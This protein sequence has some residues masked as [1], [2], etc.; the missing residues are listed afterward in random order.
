LIDLPL[1][2]IA[3]YSKRYSWL[4]SRWVRHEAEAEA[5]DPEWIAIREALAFGK[6]CVTDD[7]RHAL[8]SADLARRVAMTADEIECIEAG[9][10][11]PTIALQRWTLTCSSP[12]GLTSA[13][14]GS[15]PTQP[16]RIKQPSP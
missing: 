13:P 4:H 9:G 11:E 3:N 10:T 16:D 6:T 12:H 2:H 7:R 1:T 5:E 14:C 15:K 8:G